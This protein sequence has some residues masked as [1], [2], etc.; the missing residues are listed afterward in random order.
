MSQIDKFFQFEELFMA[1]MDLLF[2]RTAI[3]EKRGLL[4][5][6]YFDEFK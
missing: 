5:T 2:V 6:A 4:P 3:I 1:A